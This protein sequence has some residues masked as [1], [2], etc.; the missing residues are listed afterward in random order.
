M[1]NWSNLKSSINSVIKTN[2]NQ[3]ITGQVLQNVLN[4]IVSTLGENATF[5]GVATPSTNPGV[6]DGPVFYFANS[7]G[8]YS[9]FDGIE[10]EIP[11]LVILYNN[12]DG[13]WKSLKVY[14]CLQ[15]LGISTNSP[16][17]QYAA[18]AAANPA[19]Y[20][21]S[22]KINPFIKEIYIS[23]AYNGT[24]A[25]ELG[26]YISRAGCANYEDESN[27]KVIF[28][29]FAD[30]NGNNIL[31]Y[32]TT[33][34]A[35]EKDS[36]Y[37]KKEQGGLTLEFI[38][39]LPESPYDWN[40]SPDDVEAS[41][42]TDRAFNI[43]FSPTIKTIHLQN[44]TESWQ[45]T[46]Q[47]I[48]EKHTDSLEKISFNNLYVKSPKFTPFI[49]E[50]YLSGTYNGNDVSEQDFYIQ[51][52]GLYTI[53]EDSPVQQIFLIIND[54][55]GKAVVG[56]QKDIDSGG[57]YKS[58]SYYG[59]KN[60]I[61]LE[62]VA[63]LQNSEFDWNSSTDSL[64]NSKLTAN[65][66]NIDVSPT[67]NAI[68]NAKNIAE[69]DKEQKQFQFVIDNGVNKVA[70]FIKE[71]YISSDEID[72]TD[73]TFTIYRLFKYTA[74][75]ENICCGLTIK[76]SLNDSGWYFEIPG[77][78]TEDGEFTGLV[79]S[80]YYCFTT[81]NGISFEFVI[82]WENNP[83]NYNDTLDSEVITRYAY[84][85]DY[86]PTIKQ[87]HYAISE[88][89][90]KYDTDNNAFT[91]I[92]GYLRQDG[93]LNE[94]NN[95]SW[96][97]ITDYIPLKSA[98]DIEFRCAYQWNVSYCCLYDIN[99]KFLKSYVPLGYVANLTYV[100]GKMSELAGIPANAAYAIFCTITNGK[101]GV[102]GAYINSSKVV[103]DDCLNV[104]KD[105]KG[106]FI[107]DSIMIGHDNVETTLSITKFLTD[108]YG[109]NCVNKARGGAILTSSTKHYAPIYQMLTSIPNDADYIIMQ[110]GVNGM[111]KEASED[112]PWG[113]GEMSAD[114]NDMVAPEDTINQIPCLENM[115]QYV[116][117]H[118]PN[119]K[120][121]FIIT[122]K[123]GSW[124][125]YWKEKSELIK[126]VLEKWG[127]PYL[128][129]RQTGVNLASVKI[130]EQ[131]GVDAW[132]SYEEYSTEKTYAV[133]DRVLKDGNAY[134]CN[135]TISI[136]E[137]FNPEHWDLISETRYD[138]WH[139][140]AKA[141]KELADK[142][143]A[144]MKSL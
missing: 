65:A 95:T 101:N 144:W 115:C 40:S 44:E 106:Y 36:I 58:D 139:C 132:I 46:Q 88:V 123:I 136:P 25:S 93:T 57:Y 17:S 77:S 24:P 61:T 75:V 116:I 6:P 110:G 92:D 42:L 37:H 128:D 53:T 112:A 50:L 114:T 107:G 5:I 34:D 15:E 137:E 102:E 2:G 9:N 104:L 35:D 118:F 90:K 33:D 43:D 60:G 38:S 47:P 72:L 54:S 1:A 12:T 87:R 119:A 121:G 52:A 59:I 81:S 120:Y 113:W 94:I 8:V 133:D 70:A 74:S 131:Y 63:T 7:A 79:G 48:I 28:I 31:H 109:M 23:G 97:V 108:K 18:S 20:T 140:N 51:R 86:S 127:I 100:E 16:I 49:K 67:I 73:V 62:L 143:A 91:L 126:Q 66:Y 111:T 105:K 99:K 138:G 130:R 45:T 13:T 27:R 82:D 84:N 142:T 41:T 141:Y 129:W 22:G 76:S 11:G 4:T 21:N 122:Y 71:L 68:H 69:L 80:G 96:Y 56:F 103:K 78:R 26:L 3:E 32:Q 30:K 135:T 125:D 55:S 89:A 117:S 85:I 124:A 29:Y 10:L 14:E 134:K 19:F 98:Y 64:E 39:R 83:Y